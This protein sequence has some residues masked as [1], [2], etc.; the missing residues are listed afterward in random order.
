MKLKFL[1]ILS[2]FVMVPLAAPVFAAPSAD[3][4]NQTLD[5]RVNGAMAMADR[6]ADQRERDDVRKAEVT[7][8]LSHVKPG[9]R[10]LDIGAGQGYA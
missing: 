3:C 8:L 6:P 1:L 5:Q 7:F 9:D 10:V 2:V 4:A